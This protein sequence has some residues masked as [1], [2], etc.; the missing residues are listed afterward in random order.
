[1]HQ[2]P[3][4][5][6]QEGDGLEIEPSAPS[7]VGPLDPLRF[8]KAGSMIGRPPIAVHAT[9]AGQDNRL[10]ARTSLAV[11]NHESQPPAQQEGTATFGASALQ[12]AGQNT[13][14][15]RFP[16]VDQAPAYQAPAAPEQQRPNEWRNASAHLQA[17]DMLI[18]IAQRTPS[19]PQV[20]LQHL[21]SISLL[22]QSCIAA[23]AGIPGANKAAAPLQSMQSMCQSASEASLQQPHAQHAIWVSLKLLCRLVNSTFDT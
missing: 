3:P 15:V 6:H 5:P 22:C 19:S 23:L 16:Q 12:G 20:A 11:M 8:S 21:Q 2:Q 13:S 1:M 10:P 17:V 7:K 9:T 4:R 14:V 18:D